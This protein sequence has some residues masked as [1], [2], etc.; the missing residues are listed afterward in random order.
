MAEGG[1]AFARLYRTKLE[2]FT[3]L[4]DIIRSEVEVDEE[5]SARSRCG[6]SCAGGVCGAL[7][8]TMKR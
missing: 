6:E 1:D 2:S 7:G 3:Q 8:Y 5:M 4:C